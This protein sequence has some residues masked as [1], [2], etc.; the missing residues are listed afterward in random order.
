MSLLVAGRNAS[1]IASELVHARH[2]AD[3]RHARPG[4][5]PYPKAGYP[6]HRHGSGPA[7]LT[8]IADF[9][10]WSVVVHAYGMLN[11]TTSQYWRGARSNI[12]ISRKVC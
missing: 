9:W 3:R 6:A 4:H 1:G 7:L 2:R 8:I 10:D 11:I 5:G 12:T